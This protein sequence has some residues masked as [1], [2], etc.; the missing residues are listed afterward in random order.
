M[1]AQPRRVDARELLVRRPPHCVALDPLAP[2][3][4]VAGVEGRFPL[5][6]G[7]AKLP[8]F[9]GSDL[10]LRR[11]GP[12]RQERVPRAILDLDEECLLVHRVVCDL[13]KPHL[14]F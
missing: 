10:L 14:I 5:W 2:L 7:A 6:R 1:H 4:Q 13:R 12:P 8:T 11:V 9:L 3:L